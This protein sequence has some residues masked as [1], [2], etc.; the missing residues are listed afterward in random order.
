MTEK[1]SWDEIQ[2]RH[3]QEWVEL[4]DYDWADGEPYPAAGVVRVHAPERKQF[5]HLANQE[6]PHDSAILFVGDLD[7]PFGVIQNNLARISEC[8]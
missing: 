3:S 1:L 6:R 8:E 4:V 7:L 5:Y 2:K